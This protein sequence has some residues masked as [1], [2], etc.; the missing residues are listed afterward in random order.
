M[1]ERFN[2]IDKLIETDLLYGLI[3]NRY[4][5]FIWKG[6]D[7]KMGRYKKIIRAVLLVC[8][9]M[10]L[11]VIYSF[12]AKNGVSSSACSGGITKKVL[13]VI[14]PS[15]VNKDAETREKIIEKTNYYIRKTAHF[16]E[17]AILAVLITFFLLTFNMGFISAII[18]TAAVC[19]AMA[20]GDEIHQMFVDGRS[21]QIKD[22]CIDTCGACAGAV[23]AAGVCYAGKII[24]N[25]KRKEV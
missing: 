21:P 4:I 11:G 7:Y 13:K 8:I 25:R 14:Y 5:V 22:V 12:S 3:K 1:V 10:W 17:Y 2:N 9:I 16:G 6:R 20:A 19:M 15:Y 24:Y 18:F 23:F